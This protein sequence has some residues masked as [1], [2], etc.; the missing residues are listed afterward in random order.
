MYVQAACVDVASHVRT[1]LSNR[2]P[3]QGAET[4]V[5]LVSGN[6]E[7]LTGRFFGGDQQERDWVQY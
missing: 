6:P 4:P 7:G 1:T 5:W 3:E 2:T